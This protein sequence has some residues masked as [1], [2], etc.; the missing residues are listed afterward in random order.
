MDFIWEALLITA[1]GEPDGA[2]R[3]GVDYTLP[4]EA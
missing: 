1:I 2:G 3:R 4:V